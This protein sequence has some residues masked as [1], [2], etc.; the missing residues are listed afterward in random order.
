MGYARHPRARQ[1]LRAR[2]LVAAG[3]RL[4]RAAAGKG[5]GPRPRLRR[6]VQQ[7]ADRRE[8]PRASSRADEKEMYL[9]GPPLHVLAMNL[10]ARFRREFGASIPISFSAGID[11]KNFPD[12]V[13][14]GLVPVTVCSD[15]LKTGG[16]GRAPRLLHGARQAHAGGRRQRHPRLR[17]AG[18]RQRRP[19]ARQARSRFRG[20]RAGVAGARRRHPGRGHRE[21][22]G[23][24]DRPAQHRSLRRRAGERPALP[25][26]AE[27]QG[28]EAH[29]QQAGAVRLRDLR[30]L[31]ARLPQRRQLHLH[32]ARARAADR[33]GRARATAAGA[34]SARAR[35]P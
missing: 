28:A 8:P 1:R 13:A 7:H 2:H 35:S 17:P 4:H 12:A 24:T 26:R 33:E 11:Q 23:G 14:L 31:R 10:V 32:A 34:C 9:S 18:A 15:L 25:R 6:Q 30:H 5:A 16:Y 21:G 3:G 19:G 20:A 29:R 27:Q 22:V